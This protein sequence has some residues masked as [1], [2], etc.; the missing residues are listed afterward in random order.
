MV[1]I[2][3]L[4]EEL[5]ALDLPKRHYALFGSGPLLARRWIRTVNDLDVLARGPAWDRALELGNLARLEEYGVEVVTVGNYITIG[6]RWAIG[7]FD[8]DRLID[9]AELIDGIACVRLENVIA[10]KK[11][12]DRPKDRWHLDVITRHS[13]DE[14]PASEPG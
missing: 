3:P 9:E 11:L 5:L 8:T 7:D 1:E 10:Y 4:L 13:A 14:L 2:H 12:A 6:T